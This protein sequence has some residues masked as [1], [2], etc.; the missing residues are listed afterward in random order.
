MK[1][2]NC[3]AEMI[4]LIAMKRQ[5]GENIHVCPKIDYHKVDTKNHAVIIPCKR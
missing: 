3:G 1:C 2:P 5:Y 4:R